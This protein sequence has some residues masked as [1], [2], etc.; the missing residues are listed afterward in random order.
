MK[1][2]HCTSRFENSQHSFHEAF[3]VGF[4]DH[5]LHEA[6]ENITNLAI[7]KMRVKCE[8]YFRID[9]NSMVSFDV[10]YYDEKGKQINLFKKEKV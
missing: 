2:I 3:L 5:Q 9:F 10:Y 1:R 8:E 7:G 4:E 6:S